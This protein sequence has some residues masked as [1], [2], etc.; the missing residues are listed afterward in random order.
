MTSEQLSLFG[1]P[2]KKKTV[3][4]VR[5]KCVKEDSGVYS[6][7]IT[8]SQDVLELVKPIF[9]GSYCEL[10]VIVCLSNIN[11]TN[12]VSIVNIGSVCQSMV[13]PG[14]VFK[15]VLTTNSRS[16]IMIHNH[17]GGSLVPSS[18]DKEITERLKKGGELLEIDLL[19]HLILNLDCTAHYSFKEHNLI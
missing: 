4:L 14:N 6:S 7:C 3:M 10:V 2:V 8:N 9:D 12:A 11:K 15:T 16:F 19:D 5:L 18:A 17:P 1:K 13:S